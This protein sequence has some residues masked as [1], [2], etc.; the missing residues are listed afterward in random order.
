MLP[1]FGINKIALLFLTTLIAAPAIAHDV[2]TTQ[3]IGATFHIE[4]NDAPRANKPQLAWFALTQKGGKVIPLEQ[5]NCKLAVQAKPYQEG[6]PPLLEPPLK[7]ISIKRYKGIPGAEIVFPQA[8]AY[9][10]ELS[11]TPK[12]GATFKPFELSYEVNVLPGAAVQ[13]SQTNS[14]AASAQTINAH[15]Q[16]A[17][18]RWQIP[19]IAIASILTLGTAWTV[20]QRLKVKTH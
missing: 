17:D 4:P 7:E 8:G 12:A 9:E 10:L 18:N 20:W 15:T 11:G 14:Q 2:E 16:Q 6:S 13:A 5:C 3:D 19:A 1:R